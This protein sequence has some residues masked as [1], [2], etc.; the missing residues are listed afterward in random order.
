MIEIPLNNDLHQENLDSNQT[1][2]NNRYQFSDGDI[3]MIEYSDE[4]Q[5]RINVNSEE[6]LDKIDQNL[7]NILYDKDADDCTNK[8]ISTDDNY[9][10][11]EE[12]E[13]FQPDYETRKKIPVLS[14]ENIDERFDC[15]NMECLDLFHVQDVKKRLE[16][17][18]YL[19]TLKENKWDDNT[20]TTPLYKKIFSY[21]NSKGTRKLVHIDYINS[22]SNGQVYLLKP[23]NRYIIVVKSKNKL[24]NI[25][26]NQFIMW[27]LLNNETKISIMHWSMIS[28]LQTNEIVETKKP[29]ILANKYKMICI[30]PLITKS[31][32]QNSNSILKSIKKVPKY[33]EQFYISAYA[34]TCWDN[35]KVFLFQEKIDSSDQLE[36]K[37]YKLIAYGHNQLP[38]P[39]RVIVKMKTLIG[40]IYRVHGSLATIKGIFYNSED[41]K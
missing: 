18:R 17:Y 2:D 37:Y 7:G 30:N 34:P 24:E 23:G 38:N 33:G 9:T 31:T 4:K 19:P 26:T 5:D 6:N 12:F 3:D 32:S 15:N 40:D 29:L 25:K 41:V 36:R 22:R 14:S 21:E 13:Y 1:S 27:N 11:D 10:S 8:N 20:I 39:E 16:K 28:S 35:N